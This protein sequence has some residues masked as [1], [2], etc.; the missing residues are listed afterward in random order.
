MNVLSSST[1]MIC[2]GRESNTTL[3]EYRTKCTDQDFVTASKYRPCIELPDV[4]EV[5]QKL[6]INLGHR[7]L[8]H[9]RFVG[10]NMVVV[11][12]EIQQEDWLNLLRA[13]VHAE[14]VKISFPMHGTFDIPVNEFGKL[15][16]T[17]NHM[18]YEQASVIN[19]KGT[20]QRIHHDAGTQDGCWVHTSDLNQTQGNFYDQ[21]ICCRSVFDGVKTV[22][23]LPPAPVAVWTNHIVW[24]EHELDDDEQ[25]QMSLLEAIERG[26]EDIAIGIFRS[27]GMVQPHSFQNICNLMQMIIT[28]NCMR[29]F[30]H[31]VPF[32]QY[33]VENEED[34]DEDRTLRR[35]L[36]HQQTFI[37]SA[38]SASSFPSTLLYLINH[39]MFIK[40]HEDWKT[41][42]TDLFYLPTDLPSPDSMLLQS[43]PVL[44][45]LKILLDNGANLLRK[46]SHHN[47]YSG[48]DEFTEWC[49]YTNATNDTVTT[50]FDMLE[51]WYLEHSRQ[52]AYY[53][54]EDLFHPNILKIICMHR[55]HMENV[56]ESTI[57]IQ[58]YS[59][60][61]SDSIVRMLA[62]FKRRFHI[63]P[64]TLD[65]QSKNALFYTIDPRV[66]MYLIEQKV[67]PLH[68]DKDGES[69][70]FSILRKIDYGTAVYAYT[71]EQVENVYQCVNLLY[72]HNV[73]LDMNTLTKTFDLVRNMNTR[74]PEFA[75]L[76]HLIR[77]NIESRSPF[78]RDAIRTRSYAQQHT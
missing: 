69:V 16:V 11:P 33:M 13:G 53:N 50:G 12:G 22:S 77:V 10:S 25:N 75:K 46:N 8:S 74:N 62:F 78:S 24:A 48:S 68:T 64:H 32:Y 15:V 57:N 19:D 72:S 45:K 42:F 44:S 5:M 29:V 51:K 49:I 21:C 70:V 9:K 60:M 35:K 18:N 3:E 52:W 39:T 41:A 73:G 26:N 67:D 31:I 71:P 65:Q 37:A 38:M 76:L 27:M 1:C 61:S 6:D 4:I 7:L 17:D 56:D 66:V 36:Q 54:I 20:I 47:W 30:D 43:G 2:L 63:I 58:E 28:F 40:I 55:H 23:L 34:G 59:E 14:F